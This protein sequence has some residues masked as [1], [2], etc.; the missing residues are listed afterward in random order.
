MQAVDGATHNAPWHCAPENI[1]PAPSRSGDPNYVPEGGGLY[2]KV[3]RQYAGRAAPHNGKGKPRVIEEPDLTEVVDFSNLEANSEANRELIVDVTEETRARG[4]SSPYFDAGAKMYTIKSV[5]GLYFIPN[6]FSAQQQRYWVR[7]CVREYSLNQPTNLSNLEAIETGKSSF[8]TEWKLENMAKLRWAS[9]GYHYQWT[10]RVYTEEHRGTFPEDL[11]GLVRDTASLL[12]HSDM[13]AEAAI[14]NYYPHTRSMMGGH[15]D[16][17]EEAME[18][19][20]VSCSFGNTVIFLIGGRTRDVAPTALFIRSG[21][22]VLMSG[23]SRYCYHGVPRMLPN[24][25]PDY[26]TTFDP[27]TLEV[28]EEGWDA[29]LAEYMKDA[30]VNINARQVRLT[31]HDPAVPSKTD[32]DS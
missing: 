30:R 14:I 4:I 16:D 19:P 11:F 27:L 10:P 8:W 31:P 5:E 32:N 24:T 3:E 29:D 25:S 18:K 23:H 7:R 13:R 21:D 17:A 12:G 20:I 1:V 28:G 9:L 2:R 22:I 26:L 15:L 6:P